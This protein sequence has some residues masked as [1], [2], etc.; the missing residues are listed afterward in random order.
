[1]TLAGALLP[2][3]KAPASIHR[4][5]VWRGRLRAYCVIRH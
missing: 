4:H 3:P 2:T 1:M 5:P